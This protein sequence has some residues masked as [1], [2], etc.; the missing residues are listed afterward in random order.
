MNESFGPW[1]RASSLVVFLNVFVCHVCCF[2]P[3]LRFSTCLLNYL[4][5]GGP[6][7]TSGL[8]VYDLKLGRGRRMHCTVGGVMGEKRSS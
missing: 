2:F 7:S 4:S 6:T 3:W 5:M 1:M 8:Y